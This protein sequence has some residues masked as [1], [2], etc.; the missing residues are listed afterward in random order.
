MYDRWGCFRSSTITAHL[1][2]GYFIL[3]VGSGTR[4]S[5]SLMKA[6]HFFSLFKGSKNQLPKILPS[7]LLCINS[8]CKRCGS[9]FLILWFGIFLDLSL[10]MNLRVSASFCIDNTKFYVI[11]WLHYTIEPIMQTERW[12]LAH[13]FKH[14][15]KNISNPFNGYTYWSRKNGRANSMN[16]SLKRGY[17]STR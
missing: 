5:V 15:L 2:L 12:L 14:Y 9:S 3:W 16:R 17:Q 13:F 7:P 8:F 6:S 1:S 10:A 4:W 11:W